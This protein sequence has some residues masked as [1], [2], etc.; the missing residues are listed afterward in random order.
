MRTRGASTVC[1][2][3]TAIAS[4]VI[5][6]GLVSGCGSG[7]GFQ[8]ANLEG[9]SRSAA[10]AATPMT[11]AGSDTPSATPTTPPALDVCALVPPSRVQEI[12]GRDTAPTIDET[13][14]AKNAGTPDIPGVGPVANCT[15]RWAPGQTAEIVKVS[16]MPSSGQPDAATFVDVILGPEHEEVPGAGE[17][18]GISRDQLFG[19]GLAAVA[20]AKQTSAG[21]SGVLVL[22]PLESKTEAFAT[23]TNEI[24]AKL[25]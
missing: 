2:T 6:V 16:V 1:R 23:F 18:A 9:P 7:G 4:A 12:F 15:Y 13:S 20:A 11:S 10:G 17:A 19:H 8:P 21:I 25:P 14:G 22:A 24:F 3:T 5:A